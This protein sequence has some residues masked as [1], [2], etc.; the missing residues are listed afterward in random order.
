MK[1]TSL[2]DPCG[3]RFSYS[4]YCNAIVFTVAVAASACA[5]GPE[6]DNHYLTPLP[7]ERFGDTAKLLS[8]QAQLIDDASLPVPYGGEQHMDLEEGNTSEVQAADEIL[9]GF[10]VKAVDLPL[11]VLLYSLAEEAELQ[12]QL[13]QPI[14][15]PV[16]VHMVDQSLDR[17]M[18]QLALQTGI[19]WKI[20]QS[21]LSIESKEPYLHSY[22][23][24]YLNIS[25]KI[26]SEVG[27]ATQ[28]GSINLSTDSVNGVAGISNSSQSIIQNT[29]EHEFWK[30]LAADVEMI[31]TADEA[32]MGKLMLNRDAGLL[33]VSGSDRQHR[34][35]A[36]YLRKIKSVSQR[37]VLIEA[38]VVEVAL[39][40]EYQAGIDWRA[41]SSQETGINFAQIFHGMGEVASATAS[42]L[43]AP[44]A[45]LSAVHESETIGRLSATLQLL[46]NYGDVRIL[47]RPQI[48]AINN[49][50]AILKVVDNRVYFTMTIDR[51]SNDGVDDI[52]TSTEIHTV[53]VGLVMSV[54]PYIAADKTVILNVRPT[55][56]RILGFVNDPNPELAIA[57]VSNGVPE[58]QVREME[59]VLK[60]PNREIVMI[61]GLMQQQQNTNNSEIPLL[62]DLPGVGA[63]FKSK[64]RN[65]RKTELLVFLQPTVIG[66]F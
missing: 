20:Q 50:S 12:L 51:Q 45:L 66:A 39:S 43:T 63:L 30:S 34:D 53:P 57:Q 21:N 22:P 56:S 3:R 60:V 1:V 49:Q 46:Q 27:L 11:Q 37:Q 42:K 47:S 19:R 35:V 41:L 10:T 44:S 2:S 40:D 17:I 16:T 15:K 33:T 23:I 61:G 24:D 29:S 31:L 26:K 6:P 5:T 28:V 25:R 64:S 55:I 18:Q 4:I 8:A 36:D 13:D 54:T 59:S 62:S 9:D 58:I 38:T 32:P 48:I 14:D 65:S 52:S 7:E